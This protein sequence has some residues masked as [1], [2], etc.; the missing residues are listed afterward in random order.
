M[1]TTGSMGSTLKIN[2]PSEPLGPRPEPSAD[3]PLPLGDPVLRLALIRSGV[4]KPSD[5]DDIE[6]ELRGAGIAV[7]NTKTMGQS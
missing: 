3:A 4:I 2:Q 5:L 1:F 6:S 7:S